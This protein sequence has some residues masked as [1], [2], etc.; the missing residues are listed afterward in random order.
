M[1]ESV[2][3][4][5]ERVT[6][7]L[8]QL[9]LEDNTM[10][11]FYA[12]NGA[13][14]S[15]TSL[16]PLRGTK[17]MLYQ[18]GIRVPLV[19][20]WPGHV[21]AGSTCDETVVGSDLYPTFLEITGATVPQGYILDGESMIPLLKQTGSLRRE[22]IYFHSPIYLRKAYSEINYRFRTIPSSAMIKGPWKMIEFFE[23]G[24]I[25][26]YNLEDD[27]G[28]KN[29]LAEFLP[30]T[31]AML[32]TMLANWRKETKAPMTPRK[33]PD[34]V[35]LFRYR[36]LPGTGKVFDAGA[37]DSISVPVSGDCM[38]N[39][40]D[41]VILRIYHN[42][43]LF[44]ERIQKTRFSNGKSPF[45][46]N[47]KLAASTKPYKFKVY[48][49]RK[50]ITEIDTITKNVIV[51]NDNTP[52]YN[53]PVP[54]SR[55]P[56]IKLSFPSNRDKLAIEL[57]NGAGTDVVLELW[58]IKGRLL[59]ARKRNKV[60]ELIETV[61]KEWPG[62]LPYTIIVKPGGEILYKKL[63]TVDPTEVRRV[64]VEHLGRYWEHL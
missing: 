46:F 40:I 47:P 58:D 17:G 15:F 7:K 52:I 3:E 44:T 55:T 39:E 36:N 6:A 31:V 56:R 42:A 28:E 18:G 4:S 25:E 8:K 23:S 5:V 64:I 35:R 49:I 12:D 38:S 21:Q 1:I 59:Y 50:V 45:S 9:N 48:F 13:H 29:E 33:N 10:V 61:D 53:S 60:T 22:A 34:F 51:K 54:V 30:D 16:A 63:G 14:P 24:D 62:S 32:Y 2:D 57:S 41:S 37:S 43:S 26:L 27:I 11:I 20:K 19:I